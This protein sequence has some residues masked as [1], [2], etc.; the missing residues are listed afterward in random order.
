M[1]L[2]RPIGRPHMT[3]PA[4]VQFTMADRSKLIRCVVTF[5]ALRKLARRAIGTDAYEATFLAFREEIERIARR[6]YDAARVLYVPFEITPSDVVFC[7]T[8]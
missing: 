8:R 4:G 6:K 1:P 2:S 3:T 5:S 7:R